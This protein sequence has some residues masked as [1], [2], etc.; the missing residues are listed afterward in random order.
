MMLP[1]VACQGKKRKAELHSVLEKVMLKRT[2]EVQ[3]KEQ[4]PTKRDCVVFCKL[5]ELQTAMYR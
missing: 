4:L 5:S 3:L 2:K 1:V